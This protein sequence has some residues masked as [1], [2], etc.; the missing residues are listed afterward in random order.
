MPKL[1]KILIVD[2]DPVIRELLQDCLGPLN[3]ET[4]TVSR[5]RE[6]LE[7]IL[8]GE[9]SAVILDLML[10]EISGLEIL[11]RLHGQLEDTEIIVL[12]GYASVRNAVEA[13]RMGAYDY[14][15]KPFHIDAIRSA[16]KRVME[17]KHLEARLEVIHNFSQEIPLSLNVDQISL[18]ALDFVGQVL[19]A[20]DARVWLRDPESN[21]LYAVATRG[22][23]LPRG[24]KLKLGDASSPAASA[25]SQA[26]TIYIPDLKQV[27]NYQGI[28]PANQSELVVPL[29]VRNIVTGALDVASSTTDAFEPNDVALLSTLATQV[30]VMLGNARLYQHAL[31]EKTERE[32]TG[33]K[34]AQK[35]QQLEHSN[36]ALRQ[37]AHTVSQG[38]SELLRMLSGYERLLGQRYESR[39]DADADEL[40]SHVEKGMKRMQTMMRDLLTLSRRRS[41]GQ[42]SDDAPS[43]PQPPFSEKG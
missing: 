1:D 32:E 8:T 6:A 23:D 33:R 12:T 15:V 38:L 17:K 39:L 18:A 30:A 22:A 40:V 43:N 36:A 24:F 25:V 41:Q 2:D 37:F 35:V 27:S 31:Q 29:K 20:D 5:G 7:V 28:N 9:Y 19:D 16:V 4:E 21:E 10:P 3:V 11:K 26:K 42:L 34:L 13:L 14:I